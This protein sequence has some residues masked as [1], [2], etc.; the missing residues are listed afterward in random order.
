MAS[1]CHGCMVVRKQS[2][3]SWNDSVSFNTCSF[4]LSALKLAKHVLCVIGP[5]ATTHRWNLLTNT[6]PKCFVKT[7]GSK[8]SYLKSNCSPKALQPHAAHAWIKREEQGGMAIHRRF[9]LE[10]GVATSSL[11]RL[12][13]AFALV[14]AFAL[15]L[16]LGARVA[17][18]FSLWSATFGANGLSANV[19]GTFFGGCH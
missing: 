4:P 1:Y 5:A 16:A 17:L 3:C 9:L 8:G 18:G 10:E 14:F 13:C 7:L 12:G 6:C 19:L 2:N 15:G 11:A